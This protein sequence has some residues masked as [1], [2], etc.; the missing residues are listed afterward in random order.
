MAEEAFKVGDVI[1]LK[2]GGPKMTVTSVG[3]LAG[4]LSVWFDGT[5]QLHGTFPTGAVERG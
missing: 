4:T 1:K 3:D 5:K 2:S